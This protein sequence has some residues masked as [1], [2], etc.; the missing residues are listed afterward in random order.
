[1]RHAPISGAAGL[2]IVGE[3]RGSAAPVGFGCL[4]RSER[5]PD[6]DPANRFDVGRLPWTDERRQ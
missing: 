4:M 2:A 3:G 5:T 6:Q 1:M